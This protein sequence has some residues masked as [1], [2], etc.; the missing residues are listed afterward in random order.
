[1]TRKLYGESKVTPAELALLSESIRSL[2]TG[3][4]ALEVGTYHGATARLLAEAA[5]HVHLL[6]VDTFYAAHQ[7]TPEN[8]HRN[9]RANQSLFVGTA[10][11]LGKL[12]AAGFAWCFIDAMHTRQACLA[13]LDTVSAICPG[14]IFLHDYC[15]KWGGVVEAVDEFCRLEGWRIVA[16]AD[17]VVEIAPLEAAADLPPEAGR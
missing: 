5:P 16:S 4:L 12:G 8:W 11:L 15:M 9:R 1:M 13:D 17:S 7:V 3:S 10:Q 14:R 6:S 2:P